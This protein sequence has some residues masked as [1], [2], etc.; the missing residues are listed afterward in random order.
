MKKKLAFMMVLIFGLSVVLMS[1]VTMKAYFDPTAA[2]LKNPVI[3][4]ESFEV[5][6]YDGY[7]YISNKVKPTKGKAGNR[8]APLPLSF[9]FS[10][11]NPNAY[12]ILLEGFT[13]TVAFDKDFDL[14][15]LNNNDSY[16]IPAGKTTHVRATTMITTRSGLLS[17]LVTGGFKLKERKWSP[18]DALERWWKGVP[19]ASVPVT[20]KE[21]SFAFSANG[22]TKVI[23]FEATYP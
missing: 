8:G 10:V 2:N 18:W 4:L 7:W 13:F 9:L 12:P 23:A 19:E 11:K 6:Q 14:V 17:L 21:G 15:T 20:V 1:C 3:K 22:V 5:P 16:W